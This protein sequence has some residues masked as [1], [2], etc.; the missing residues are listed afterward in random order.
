M[1]CAENVRVD[2]RKVVVTWVNSLENR[3]FKLRVCVR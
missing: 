2:V 1:V 3:P